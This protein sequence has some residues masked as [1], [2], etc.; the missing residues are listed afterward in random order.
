MRLLLD[1]HFLYW[2]ALEPALVSREERAL[3]ARA[4]NTIIASPVSI[5][6]VRLKWTRRDGR[7][8]RKGTLAPE[9]AIALLEGMGIELPALTGPDCAMPL[10]PPLGHGDPFDEMLLIHA[11]QLGARLLTRDRLLTDHPLAYRP[12]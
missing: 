1:T 9:R 3:I 4:E 11:R 10:D 5:W 12:A 6:E 2:F 7:G 8:R